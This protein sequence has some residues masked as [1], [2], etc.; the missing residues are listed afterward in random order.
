[1]RPRASGVA[2]SALR[3]ADRA[4]GELTGLTILIYQAAVSRRLPRVCVFEPSCS[5]FT[6]IAMARHGFAAGVQMGIGRLRRCRGGP[7]L[8]EDSDEGGIA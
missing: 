3:I 5:E 8:G 1:M 4:L 2:R 6:R 7:F